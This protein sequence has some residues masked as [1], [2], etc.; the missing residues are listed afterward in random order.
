MVGY[1]LW[2]IPYT[3]WLLLLGLKHS[4]K[5]TGKDT[6]YRANVLKNSAISSIIVGKKK[7]SENDIKSSTVA[8]KY[9]IMHAILCNI[10]FSWGYACYTSYRIHTIFCT[11][12]VVSA[13]YQGGVKYYKMTTKWYLKAVEKMLDDG[14]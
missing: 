6:V 7:A 14:K 8:M 9:M 1:F 2:W 3:L 11:I 10:A 12:L 5:T 4:P 13:I